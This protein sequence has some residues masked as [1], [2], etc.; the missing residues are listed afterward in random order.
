MHLKGQALPTGWAFR[1]WPRSTRILGCEPGGPCGLRLDMAISMPKW[2]L[3]VRKPS[4][5][6]VLQFALMPSGDAGYPQ[7]RP[8]KLEELTE[9]DSEAMTHG[10][11]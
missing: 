8:W 9:S 5:A 6:T 4:K 1:T 7:A 10:I 3:V 2:E 11:T